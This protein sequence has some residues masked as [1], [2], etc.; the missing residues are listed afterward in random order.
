MRRMKMKKLLFG[1]LLASAATSFAAIDPSYVDPNPYAGY[2]EAMASVSNDP[3]AVEW[4]A[5]NRKTLEFVNDAWCR[6]VFAG[7]R[8]ELLGY[9]DKVKGAY[10]SDPLLLVRIAALTQYAMTAK[11]AWWT[12]GFG[13]VKERRIWTELLIEKAASAS[14][15]YVKMFLIDQLRWCA[16]SDQACRIRKIADA[17]NDKGVKS[18]AEIAI[19][20][21]GK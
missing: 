11:P 20:E 4:H 7:G 19:L 8:D 1:I 2:D 14:D 17:S 6:T 15:P 16:Y 13:D 12:F 21:V 10:L 5:A 9:V 18:I 3:M